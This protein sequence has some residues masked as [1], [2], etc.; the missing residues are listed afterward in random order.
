MKNEVQLIAYVDRLGGGNLTDLQALLA[1]PL[2]GLFGCVHALPFFYPIDGADTGFDPIDHLAVD[3]R[4]GDWDDIRR[5]ARECDVAADLI[6]NHVSAQS[7][8]F[9]D[10][11]EKGDDS[12]FASMFLTMEKVFP[13]G[14]SEDDLNRIYR[15]RPSSPFVTLSL[16][17]GSSRAF[18][19]TFT[20]QQIDLDVGDPNAIAYIKSILEKLAANGVSLVRLDAIGYAIKTPGT[21]CFMTPETYDFIDVVTGWAHE[22]GLEVLAEIHTH[23]EQQIEAAKHVDY[24]YDFALPPLVLHSIFEADAQALKDWFAISPRNVLTVLDTHDG[25]GVMDVGP[26]RMDP[27]TKGLIA[28]EFIDSMVEKIHTNSGGVSRRASRHDV[29]NLDLYQVNCTFYDALAGDDRAYL[30]ARLIQFFA[31]GIPQV[32][33]VGLFASHNSEALLDATGAG[34]DVNRHYYTRREIDERL[35]MPVV[36]S[37]LAMI[38]FRN[39]HPAFDGDFSV[40]YSAPHTLHIRRQNGAHWAEARVDLRTRRYKVT[41]SDADGTNPLALQM[42]T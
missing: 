4:L 14:L 21:S 34:R 11:L 24:V 3:Q 40:L 8:Q 30:L 33:Y 25:I 10:V 1:G 23:Y 26:D 13:N 32:Y 6:V 18:W 9:A 15:P 12:Q 42:S 39:R 31:P 22:V 28:P 37:L 2:E 16:G 20:E 5:L 19:A 36:Q 41:C 35:A 29:G 7:A 27:T 17:D 38:R